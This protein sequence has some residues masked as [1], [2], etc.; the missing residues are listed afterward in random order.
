MKT[1]KITEI[2][3]YPE[4]DESIPFS[5]TLHLFIQFINVMTRQL[6]AGIVEQEWVALARQ[7]HGKN[8][9]TATNQHNNRG[10]LGSGV[11]CGVHADAI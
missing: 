5:H 6:K 9:F 1:L 2:R 8:I 7:R 4:L 3:P 10:T 11:F